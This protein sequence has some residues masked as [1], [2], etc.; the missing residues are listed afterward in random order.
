MH[1][2]VFAPCLLRK[3][4]LGDEILILA[5]KL[6]FIMAKLSV[7]LGCNIPFPSTRM[8]FKNNRNKITNL[9]PT[10]S[11][12]GTRDYWPQVN[13]W[14]YSDLPCHIMISVI[15]NYHR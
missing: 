15:G 5:Y 6:K 4:L 13:L 3:I 1:T 14:Q 7:P 9:L 10:V 12:G 8:T 2:S 11:Q